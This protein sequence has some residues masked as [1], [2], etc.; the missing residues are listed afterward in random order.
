MHSKPAAAVLLIGLALAGCGSH[1]PD[2]YDAYKACE[3]WVGE[4][5]KAPSTADF[6]GHGDSQIVETENGYDIK[7]YVDAEN[8]FGAQI[9]TN[10]SCNVALS[11][12]NWELLDLNVS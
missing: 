5:L 3:N 1:K 2:D 10:W 6:S 4:Q 8:G 7:G 9:R 11:G 12:D